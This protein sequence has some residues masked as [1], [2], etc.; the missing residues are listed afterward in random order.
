MRRRALLTTLFLAYV[1]ATTQAQT[2]APRRG[3]LSRVLHPFSS[4]EKIP[5]YSNPKL[6]GL[7]LSIDLPDE[8]IK[9]TEMRQLPVTVRLTNVGKRAVELS[10]PTEQRIEILLH[11]SSGRVVTRWSENRAF[12]ST[13]GM[14]LINPNEHLEWSET[15]ATRELAPG[16]VFTIEATVPAYPELDVKRKAIAAP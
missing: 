7:Q 6:T 13:P 5:T 12:A 14:A 11:D 15:I 8:T 4:T 9:L 10:F 2:S 16:R 3:F 1:I